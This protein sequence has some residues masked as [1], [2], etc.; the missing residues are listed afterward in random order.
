MTLVWVTEASHLTDY[1]IK[2][3]FN[4]GLKGVIDLKNHI[5]H[6]IF[7]P[8]RDVNEF[9]KFKKNSWTIE[10]DCQVDFAPEFLYQLAKN[11]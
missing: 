3:T 2:I 8:L 10:W 1:K 4:D 9:K 11:S 7:K 6:K 5:K